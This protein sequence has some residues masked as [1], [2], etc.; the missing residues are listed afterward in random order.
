M[1]NLAYDNN[2]SVINTYENN[3]L[4]IRSNFYDL[5]E[6][7]SCKGWDKE[8]I[9]HVLKYRARIKGIIQY[10]MRRNGIQ[11]VEVDDIYQDLLNDLYEVDDYDILMENRS[12]SVFHYISKRLEFIMHRVTTSYYKNKK[13]MSRNTLENEDGDETSIFDLLEAENRD[14][15]NTI[16]QIEYEDIEAYIDDIE[17]RRYYFGFDIYQFFYVFISLKD[18]VETSELWGAISV[19]C[20]VDIK[21]ISS[22]RDEI[23]RNVDFRSFVLVLTMADKDKVLSILGKYVYG[24]KQIDKLIAFECE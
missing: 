1:H 8:T 23:Y 14:E 18:K 9:T 12:R 19:V 20:C 4:T 10:S 16:Q 11:A 17:C 6:V 24:K 2:D 3:G 21:D 13:L 22:G 5:K 7:E 15:E